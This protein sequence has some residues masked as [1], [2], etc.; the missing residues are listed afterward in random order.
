MY[1]HIPK[2]LIVSYPRGDAKFWNYTKIT[3]YSPRSFFL[4]LTVNI[5][6]VHLMKGKSFS[7]APR[8]K[9]QTAYVYLIFS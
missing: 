8:C 9:T 7:L 2:N 5:I 4:P 1:I 3:V 6:I